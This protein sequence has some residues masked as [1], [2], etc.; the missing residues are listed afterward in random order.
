MRLSSRLR[1]N[2]ALLACL[3]LTGL[4]VAGCGGG[5][6][7]STSGTPVSAVS[8]TPP[9][10][11]CGS[12]T[13]PP[14]RDDSGVLAKLPAEYR[15]NYRG[16]HV[17]PSKWSAWKPSHPGPYKVQIVW[18]GLVNS[19]IT[20][21]QN[22]IKSGLEKSGLTSDVRVTNTADNIDTAAQIQQLQAAIRRNPDLIILLPLQPDAFTSSVEQAGARGIPVIS[23]INTINSPYSVN[24]DINSYLNTALTSSI[25]ARSLGGKG[26]VLT[27]GGYPGTTPSEH[28][29]AGVDAVL[30]HCPGMKKI[31]AVSGLFTNAP[32]KS[33]VT[34]FLATHP[35]PVD[36]AVQVGGMGPGVLSAFKGVR[37][38]MPALADIGASNGTLGYWLKNQST[39]R[40]AAVGQSAGGT[41]AGVVDVATRLLKGRGPRVNTMIPPV[42][43]ITTKNLKDWAK[44]SYTLDTPG[45]ADGPPDFRLFPDRYL[46][47]LFT[48]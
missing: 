8:A 3:A 42:T 17:L 47:P 33:A 12:F 45:V 26:T 29:L 14:L 2:A 39:F 5:A 40:S 35:G 6:K 46:D 28:G 21:L 41:A 31:G 20:D 48:H 36:M 15:R 1:A 37:R 32:A 11:G 18:S 9:A 19:F 44:P 4:A 38:P 25:L 30:K 7:G 22:D 27:V 43:L 13:L 23:V 34:Q 16:L 10:T 24:V